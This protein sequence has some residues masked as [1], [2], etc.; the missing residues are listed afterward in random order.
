MQP[1]SFDTLCQRIDEL[2]KSGRIKSDIAARLRL[3]NQANDNNRA[4]KIWFC[5]FPPY[6][7]GESGIERFFRR[8]GGEAL[9]NLHESDPE[10][11]LALT[12]LGRPCLIEAEV[13]IDSLRENNLAFLIYRRYLVNRGYKTVENLDYED[14]STRAILATSIR[15]PIIFPELDFLR[16]TG[17]NS[18]RTPLE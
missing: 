16:L 1:P 6:L 7:A 9:Y 18:W 3:E 5:F 11:G 2:K 4:G 8:W 13:R 15:R 10:T 12:K 17:C 14:F